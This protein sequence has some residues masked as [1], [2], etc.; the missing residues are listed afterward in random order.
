MLA[1]NNTDGSNFD[2]HPFTGERF[3]L[4]KRN[5]TRQTGYVVHSDW[6]DHAQ[7]NVP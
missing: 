6:L 3:T 7:R 1:V 2:G 5:N 4:G